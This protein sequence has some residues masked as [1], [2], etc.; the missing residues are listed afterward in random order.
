MSVEA[1]EKAQNNGRSRFRLIKR[2]NGD[3]RGV[4]AIEFAILA[5][6]FLLVLF[7][8]L[9]SSIS[10]ASQQLMADTVDH[11]ARDIRVANIRK[12]GTGSSPAEIKDR[13]C[14]E[15]EF[16]VEDGCPGLEVDLKVYADYNDI[17]VTIPRQANND[18]DTS[19]FDIKVGGNSEKQ[20]LRVFYRWKYMTKFIADKSATL[21]DGKTLLYAAAV[22]KI[23]PLME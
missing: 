9:E 6:P 17:P 4:A 10:F 7:A 2:F 14:T 20:M 19:G 11:L 18:I 1:K 21:P 3:E 5:M 15:L 22:W 12:G 8:V 23:E 16:F 13:I